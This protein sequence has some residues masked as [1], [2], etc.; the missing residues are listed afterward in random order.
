MVMI[1]IV[2]NDPKYYDFVRLLRSDLRVQD[3]FIEVVNITKDQQDKYMKKHIDKYIVALYNNEPAGFA[4][5]LDND[6]RVCVHPDYQGKGI[7]KSLII[8]LMKRFPDSFAKVKIENEASRK[9]FE[10][11]GFEIKYWL[12]EK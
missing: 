1:K 3:G 7:G 2:N 10:S 5:S 4:G 12:M 11:C 6:I 9:L 8:E